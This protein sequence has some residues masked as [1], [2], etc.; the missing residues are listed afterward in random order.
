MGLYI[1]IQSFLRDYPTQARFCFRYFPYQDHGS[2]VQCSILTK[3][4]FFNALSGGSDAMMFYRLPKINTDFKQNLK[5]NLKLNFK[6]VLFC[7][8]FKFQE[9]F[10]VFVVMFKSNLVR[11]IYIMFYLAQ[12]NFVFAPCRNFSFGNRGRGRR[13]VRSR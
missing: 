8:N 7:E 12:L 10:I 6:L 5:Q 4:Y 2:L 9:R 13:T 1:Q 11:Y 3:V